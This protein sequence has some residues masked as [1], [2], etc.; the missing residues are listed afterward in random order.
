MADINENI[1]L[2]KEL[3]ENATFFKTDVSDYDSQARTFQS[4]WDKWGR[5]DALCANAGIVDRRYVEFQ[6]SDFKQW[7]NDER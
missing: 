5:I 7:N 2:S 3:G 4:T 1:E 6:A